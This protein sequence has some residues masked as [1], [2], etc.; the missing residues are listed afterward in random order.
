MIKNTIILFVCLPK[1][2]IYIVF[3]FS[4]LFMLMFMQTFGGQT[5]EYYGIFKLTQWPPLT[6]A[7]RSMFDIGAH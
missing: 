2:C 1:V 3:I 6:A 7:V 4:A 5:K